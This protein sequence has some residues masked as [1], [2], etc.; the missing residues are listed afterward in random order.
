MSESSLGRTTVFRFD[1]RKG[2]TDDER[3]ARV[4]PVDVPDDGRVR[5]VT[6]DGR[7]VALA[8]CW[9]QLGALE[10]RCPR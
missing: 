2:V 4:D 6:V 5:T 8:R 9:A 7:S 1:G 3:M 10:N